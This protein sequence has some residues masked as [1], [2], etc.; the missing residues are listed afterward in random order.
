MGYGVVTAAAAGALGRKA[1]RLTPSV[2]REKFVAWMDRRRATTGGTVLLG[3]LG[4]LV[5]LLFIQDPR[6][7]TDLLVVGAGLWLTYLSVVELMGLVRRQVTEA[8]AGASPE[9][10]RRARLRHVAIAGGVAA[11]AIGLV[12][13]GL[14]TS[15]RRAAHQAEALGIEE[16]NGAASR[17]DLALN[18]V[19]FPGTHNSMSSALYPGWLF[20][21]QVNTIRD[22][23]NAGVR[24]LLIDTHY[25]VPSTAKL[26]GSESP[27]VLTDRAA[28]LVAPPGEEIDPAVVERANQLAARAPKAAN[29]DRAIY[30]CHNYCELGAVTFASVLADVKAFLD[31]HPGEVV[32]LDIQDATSPADTAADIEQAGLGDRVATLQKGQALPKLRDLIDAGTTLLVFAEQGG[33]GGPPWYHQMYDWFQETPFNYPSVDGFDCQPNRGTAASPMFLINH[34]VSKKGL[35]DPAAASAANKAEVLTAR[36]ERC[37]NE[38]GLLPNIVAV[39][40]GGR[41]DLV[42]TAAGVNEDLLGLLAS[43]D[44]VK[45][46]G[47]TAPGQTTSTIAPTVPATGPAPSAPPL[48]VAPITTLTGGDPAALCAVLGDTRKVLFGWA[49]A[50]STEPESEA[51]RDDLAFAPALVRRLPPFLAAAPTELVARAQPVFERAQAA[52]SAL[53]TLGLDDQ[54][55]AQLADRADEELAAVTGLDTTGVETALAAALVEQVGE[56][57]VAAAAQAFASSHPQA[58]DLFDLGEVPDTV[59]QDSGYGCLTSP[60]G[61]IDLGQGP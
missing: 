55:I 50:A 29:A 19:V 36:M 48:T 61:L 43:T 13:V 28:G 10:R 46:P 3:L 38:R 34:W 54:A 53:R 35:A 44:G 2:V 42:S 21:E 56:A 22:Q 40:F 24:A 39:D 1:T 49:L 33:P 23:L 12:T 4:L 27:I 26:P 11:V 25:G 60:A 14:V 52:V 31:T 41:G 30:L 17:C 32:I 7:N 47:S 57:R 16:C 6:G 58:P 45:Q 51:G 9:E 8:G 15:T 59:A 37:L 20:G 18:Q 5:G